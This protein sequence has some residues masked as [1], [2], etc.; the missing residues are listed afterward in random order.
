MEIER[1]CCL[2]AEHGADIGMTAGDRFFLK[3]QHFLLRA[4]DREP[5]GILKGHVGNERS[6]HDL[7]RRLE[8]R[9]DHLVNRRHEFRRRLVG[10]FEVEKQRQFL[11][12]ADGR[13]I[14]QRFLRAA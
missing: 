3:L 8:K 12:E 13:Y 4:G 5:H 11:I 1:A 7:A 10:L 2:G 9:S 6:L 14:E